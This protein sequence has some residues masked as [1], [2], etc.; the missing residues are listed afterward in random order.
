MPNRFAVSAAVS[1]APRSRRR[2][3]RIVVGFAVGLVVVLA[4][5]AS[6]VAEAQSLSLDRLRADGVVGERYDGLAAVRAAD[7]PRSV[8]AFIDEVNAKRRKIYLDRAAEQGVPPDQV[9]RIY[10]RQIA[11]DM[12]A[13]TWL[14]TDRNVWVQK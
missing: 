11:A 2:F 14:F 7:A 8:H 10:A 13:G 5:V 6:G 3:Y 12:P 4:L 1:A 9:G